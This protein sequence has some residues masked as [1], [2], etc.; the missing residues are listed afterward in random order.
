MSAP[1]SESAH[2]SDNVA[3]R[4]EA[5]AVQMLGPV[6][7]LFAALAL[8][9]KA[10]KPIVR[11]KTVR[12]QS[13]K[14]NYTFDYAPLESVLDATRDALADNGLCLFQP[15]GHEES[16]ELSLTTVLAHKDGGRIVSRMFLP[17]TAV[18][19]GDG[20]QSFER[21][22]T[23]QEIGSAITYM[24][25][26]M[27]QSVLGVNA[28]EDDDGAGG[29]EMHR[30]TQPRSQPTPPKV[31]Q[32]RKPVQQSAPKA[33]SDETR[34]FRKEVLKKMAE[35]APAHDATQPLDPP[36]DRSS[37]P[38]PDGQRVT[39]ET[40]EKLRSLMGAMGLKGDALAKWCVGV[41]GKPPGETVLESEY[42]TL[43]AKAEAEL[44]SRPNGATP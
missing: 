41:L 31:D 1:E 9:Q 33:M 15:L 39:P 10:F 26:Y 12:V 28:E 24:R 43:I 13:S 32:A 29:E 21:Q 23:A 14:G 7:S 37:Q 19:R 30:Q 38:P 42:R 3:I 11:S 5:G 6:A 36:Q 20:G 4:Q 22:K 17:Q 34:E 8:A 40:K 18:Q 44:A 35:D 2:I 16:G 27:A 25:R